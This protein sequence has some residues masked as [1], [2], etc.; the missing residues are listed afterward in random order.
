[1]SYDSVF[2][3]CVDLFRGRPVERGGGIAAIRDDGLVLH[4][5]AA[6]AGSHS[7]K[8][9][10]GVSPWGPEVET[11]VEADPSAFGAAQML[12]RMTDTQG[13]HRV[14]SDGLN[15]SMLLGNLGA[16]PDLRYTQGGQA[17]CNLRLATTESY[18]DKSGEMQERTDWHNVVVW[19]KRGEALGKLLKKGERIFVEGGLRTSSYEDKNGE[20]RFKTEVHATSVILMGAKGAAEE[21]AAQPAAQPARQADARRGPAARRAATPATHYGNSDDDMPF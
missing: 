4:K 8:S 15:R 11:V 10:V 9:I 7:S 19:G 3:L 13:R 18:K 16:D 21:S 5:G 17:V 14:M 2:T 12:V 6:V 1:M 20:K